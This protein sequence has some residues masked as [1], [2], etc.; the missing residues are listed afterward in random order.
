M[1]KIHSSITTTSMFPAYRQAGV[2]LCKYMLP[3]YHLLANLM[4]QFLKHYPLKDILA[5]LS[6]V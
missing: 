4:A 3:V 5:G 2:N 6:V 1:V